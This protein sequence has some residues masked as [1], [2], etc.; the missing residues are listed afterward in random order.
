MEIDSLR[1]IGRIGSF[2]RRPVRPAQPPPGETVFIGRLLTQADIDAANAHHDALARR[3]M[4][5]SGRGPF[6]PRT[7]R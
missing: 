7:S 2:L 5:E 3:D 1:L 6:T 4:R